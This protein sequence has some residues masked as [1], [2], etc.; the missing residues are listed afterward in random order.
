MICNNCGQQL[1]DESVFC[2]N[3]G[4]RQNEIT[5]DTI[6]TVRYPE[7]ENDYPAPAAPYPEETVDYQAS[8]N[9][10][11]EETVDYQAQE[12]GYFTPDG[13]SQ[14]DAILYSEEEPEVHD[15]ATPDPDEPITASQQQAPSAGIASNP[16]IVTLEPV[17]EKTNVLVPQPKSS[18]GYKVFGKIVKAFFSVVFAIITFALI[19][20]LTV[21][22]I[23]Q[24]ANI[25]DM[26]AGID[27]AA[28][29]DDP[30]VN[31]AIEQWLEDSPYSNMNIDIEEIKEY[32]TREDLPIE[33]SK[34][35]E[36]AMEDSIAPYLLFSIYPLI[37]VATLCALAIFDIFM[38][39]R[40]TVRLAFLTAGIP[41]A[42]SGLVFFGSGLILRN[43]PGILW[44]RPLRVIAGFIDGIS[45]LL[46]LYGIIVF[47]VGILSIILFI[48]ILIVRKSRNSR[49]PGPVEVIVPKTTEV[50]RVTGI[51][52]NFTLLMACT[53]VLF[54][55]YLN[56]PW[57]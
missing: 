55:Y 57:R 35:I 45:H 39:H 28:I 2:T 27:A 29:L 20:A 12:T 47:A 42:A 32:L 52:A 19:S 40:K 4:S 44:S 37:I 49:T 15:S 41:I 22:L 18:S 16:N 3:C 36:T 21:I 53:V 43:F 26:V 56:I 31:E 51:I 7:A 50:W 25:P 23:V 11:P 54:I 8:V 10:Y 5:V 9:P 6:P 1:K 46:F 33:I 17:P 48:V 24:P 14:P 30:A 38:I 34:E 13:T